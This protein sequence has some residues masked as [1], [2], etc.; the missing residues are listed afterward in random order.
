MTP[1]RIT[2]A[3]IAALREWVDV[4]RPAA[5]WNSAATAEAIWRFAAGVGD[6]NPLWWSEDYCATTPLGRMAAPPTFLYS[7]NNG[8]PHPGADRMHPSES[9]LPGTVNMWVSDRW[10][11][12]RPVFADERIDAVEKLVEVSE[13]QGRDGTPRVIHTDET[14]FSVAGATVARVYK[15]VLRRERGNSTAA[16]PVIPVPSY[17]EADRS[18]L[19]ASYA[20][21]QARRRGADVRFG[22][23]V[24]TGDSL[25]PLLKGPLTVSNIVGWLLGW[26]SPMAFTNRMLHDYLDAHPG[27][28]LLDEALGADDTIESAHWNSGLAQQ[29]GSA[30]AY[31]FAPQRI[32]WAAHLI[33]DWMGDAGFLAELEVRLLAQNLIGDLLTLNGTVTE[34]E[35]AGADFAISCSVDAVNQR[36]QPV[37]AGTAIVKLPARDK[38]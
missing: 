32:S 5:G 27:S 4:P 12:E 6:D 25:G 10:L 15:T 30:R 36:G 18:L 26:G 28:R 19:K 29:G 22:D 34:V 8:P 24:E 11:F 1:A 35:R 21:E 2:A 31:D 37:L 16:A 3:E 23:D 13:R 17:T 33:T 14:E 20:E 9:W 7:C 38:P